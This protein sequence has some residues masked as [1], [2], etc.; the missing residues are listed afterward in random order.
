[1]HVSSTYRPQ[2]LLLPQGNLSATVSYTFSAK[3]RDPETGLSY[4]GARYYTSDL[5]IWLSV[6]PMAAK[7]PSLSP[8]V[9]CA[10]N[11]VKL[12][13]PNGEEY[14]IPPF[15]LGGFPALI[16][17][18][19]AKNSTL[20]ISNTHQAIKHYYYGNGNTVNLDSKF[21]MALMNT[22]P[23]KEMHQKIISGTNFD[24]N[25]NL[26][27]SG[28]FGVN[29]TR[30]KG[31]F[32][33]GHTGVKY[34]VSTSEDKK[35]CTVTYEFFMKG[36]NPDNFSDPNFLMERTNANEK[37]AN[38]RDDRSGHTGDDIGP[39]LELGGTPYKFNTQKKKFIFE[40]P[41]AYE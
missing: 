23:F 5:S 24:K 25:G 17:Q 22:N 30:E 36:D 4:F 35:T 39:K 21:T 12:V 29:M 41:G 11:P 32:F 26:I 31:A 6:D 16:Y 7:Y 33:I 2:N 27:T 18:I 13:D 20:T 10:N 9:Y 15:I 40:N 8:Y 37:D 34:E 19:K 38:K 14:G 3:E 28:S 1:M